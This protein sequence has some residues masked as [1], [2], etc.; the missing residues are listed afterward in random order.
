MP[1]PFGSHDADAL[2]PPDHQVDVEQDGVVGVERDVDSL[3]REHALAAADAAAQGERHLAA[4]EHRLLDL[5]HPVD[6]HLLDARLA[7]G[8]LV[9]ADVRPVPEAADRLLEPGDLLLLGDVL[10]ALP[11]ELELPGDRIGGVAAGPDPDP[12]AV[13]LRDRADA[14]VEQMAVVRDHQGRAV[15][16]TDDPLQLIPAAHVEV[17]LR[18]VEHQH[19]RAAGE[20]GGERCELT[21]AATQLG[22][23][24]PVGHPEPFE[25]A[26]RLGVGAVAAVL[27]PAGQ[28]ALLVR[29]R[30]SDRVEVGGQRGIGQPALHRVQLRLELGQLRAGGVH[31]A[32][33]RPLVA[34]HVLRQEGVHEPAPAGHRAGVGMLEPGEDPQQRRLP[35]AVRP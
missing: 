7:R 21:L 5:L 19:L 32:E 4:L 24:E 20:A 12:P 3:E 33:R 11:L 14:R 28:K 30:A 1:A 31:P 35:A 34:R 16:L 27:G 10:S 18:L 15:E 13:E 17:R 29:E 26:A 8:P 22:G 9:D 23:R 6:L 2:A 25:Q